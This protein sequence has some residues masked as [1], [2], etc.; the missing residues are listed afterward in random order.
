MLSNCRHP[1][2]A[3][4]RNV[5]SVSG[6]CDDELRTRSRDVS[7]DNIIVS[8]IS[9]VNGDC[10]TR[11][12]RSEG[13]HLAEDRVVGHCMG[14]GIIPGRSDVNGSSIVT[15]GTCVDHGGRNSRSYAHNEY[16]CEANFH[17]K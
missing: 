8:S 4:R 11:Q 14:G 13:G 5:G 6:I 10:E 15:G 12:Q 7:I 17:E 16:Q 1:T 2:E 9:T 3:Q